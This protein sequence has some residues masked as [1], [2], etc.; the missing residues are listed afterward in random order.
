MEDFLEKV[1][2]WAFENMGISIP[3][4]EKIYRAKEK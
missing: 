3:L 1:R 4:P 2:N